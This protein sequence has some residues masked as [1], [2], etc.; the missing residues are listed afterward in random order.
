MLTEINKTFRAEEDWI[1]IDLSLNVIYYN[2]LL[3]I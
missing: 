2:H 3:Q 1:V